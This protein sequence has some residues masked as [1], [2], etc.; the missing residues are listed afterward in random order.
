MFIHLEVALINVAPGSYRSQNA[1]GLISNPSVF[2]NQ[3]LYRERPCD[4]EQDK[5]LR[6]CVSLIEILIFPRGWLYNTESITAAAGWGLLAWNTWIPYTW[7]LQCFYQ[8]IISLVKS[9][10]LPL[11]DGRLKHWCIKLCSSTAAWKMHFPSRGCSCVSRPKQSM[12]S[13]FLHDHMA[14]CVILGRSTRDEWGMVV[15]VSVNVC[16]SGCL[17][18]QTFPES[19]IT[20]SRTFNTTQTSFNPAVTHPIWLVRNE[21]SSSLR[22]WVDSWTRRL[23]FWIRKE[24][25]S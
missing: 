23:N 20:R 21:I 1:L 3:V 12:D 4:L 2:N 19:N 25:G 16:V 11:Q 18:C 15:V 6:H 17:E 9:T 22:T 8:F 13:S 14:F 5:T 24:G 10:I 7:I